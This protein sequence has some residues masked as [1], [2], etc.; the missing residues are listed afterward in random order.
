MEKLDPPEWMSQL[1][2]ELSTVPL[3]DLAIPGECGLTPLMDFN[4]GC[5]YNNVQFIPS[6]SVVTDIKQSILDFKRFNQALC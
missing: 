6:F 1:P 4:P 3:W 5:N 2:S